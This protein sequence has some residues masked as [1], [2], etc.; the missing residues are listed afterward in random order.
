MKN[1]VS[2]LQQLVAIPSPN[3]PGD[4][5]ALAQF[6]ATFLRE[7][8]CQVEIFAPDDRAASTI[9]ILGSGD[10]PVILY[11]AHID[12]VPE[13]EKSKWSM[14]P[15]SGEIR[16]GKLFGRGAVDDKAALAA[17]M[18]TV[19]WL[20][21][22]AAHLKGRLIL[23]AAADEEMGG[24][25]GTRWLVEHGHIPFADFVVVGEQTHNQ[26]AIAHKGVV[27][28]TIKTIGKTAHATNPSLGVNAIVQ[29]ARVIGELETYNKT[30]QQRKHPLVGAPSVNIGTI[31]G[32]VMAN[33]VPEACVIQIDRR[34]VPG[35]KPEAVIEE[36][37]EVLSNLALA[38][39]NFRYELSE[40]KVSNSFDTDGS[41]AFTQ[42]FL[43]VVAHVLNQDRRVV[44]Y[45]PG[46]DAK[47]LTGIARQ[48]MI[49]F[50][51]GTYQVAH[52]P[53][54]HVSVQELGDAEDILVDFAQRTLLGRQVDW[55]G[56]G[57]QNNA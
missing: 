47:H 16:D 26:V 54:E 12:T 31:S 45:L 34:F 39:S 9:G 19:S 20:A 32:G 53:D 6:I 30:L 50:G 55:K 8:K 7:N 56:E 5:R 37:R 38:D 14:N 28:A 17:M 15:F 46:S 13:G 21:P 23:V 33:V 36:I 40:I 25:L 18:A 1:S 10:G 4:T 57:R 48:G 43:S 35:E 24:T 27:R 44:G 41:D 42:E 52:A 3:P 11:H 2:L 51:P 29:M 49:V 22:Q